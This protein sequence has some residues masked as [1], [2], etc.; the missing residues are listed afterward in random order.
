M[1]RKCPVVTAEP[2]S[3]GDTKATVLAGASEAGQR[4]DRALAPHLPALSRT[5][6]KRLIP[7]GHVKYE[8]MALRA[9]A[10]R[11]RCG[12]HFVVIFPQDT[13]SAPLAQPMALHN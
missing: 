1:R 6:L 13:H 9:P 4:I 2:D 3:P 11:V 5:P 10:L 12:Q 7:S 8:G